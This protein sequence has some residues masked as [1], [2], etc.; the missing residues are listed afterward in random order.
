MEVDCIK[1]AERDRQRDDTHDLSRPLDTLEVL[2]VLFH[3]RGGVVRSEV[4][5][6]PDTSIARRHAAH[7]RSKNEYFDL[8]S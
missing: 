7:D 1:H 6:R 4:K 5:A 8:D 2:R 3:G